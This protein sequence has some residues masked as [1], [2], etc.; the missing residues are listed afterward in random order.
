MTLSSIPFFRSHLWLGTRERNPRAA[1]KPCK[2]EVYSVPV[3]FRIF[4]PR[5]RNPMTA[6]TALNR[7]T[8]RLRKGCRL[9]T[10][11]P[12]KTATKDF[13]CEL[14]AHNGLGGAEPR[15]YAIAR[16]RKPLRV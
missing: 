5:E 3:L 12:L 1:P 4:R 8:E 15:D 7:A 10:S 16:R 6:R 13:A 11:L 14:H 2:I 9:P